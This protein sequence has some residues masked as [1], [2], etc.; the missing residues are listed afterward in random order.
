MNAAAL[1]AFNTVTHA[2]LLAAFPATLTIAGTDCACVRGPWRNHASF[3]DRT[4]QPVETRRITVRVL[5]S[6]L[7]AAAATVTP[8]TTSVSLDGIAAVVVE[9]HQFPTDPAF[10]LVLESAALT[11]AQT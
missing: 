11:A 4:Q 5:K 8:H 10:S 2:A 6:L 9:V 3:D 1:A 7:T